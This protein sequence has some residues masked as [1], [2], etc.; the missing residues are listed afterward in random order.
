MEACSPF[1]LEMLDVF[2]PSIATAEGQSW[3]TQRRIATRCFNEQSNEIV[4]AE[5]LTLANDMLGYWYSKPE[6]TSAAN[7]LRTLSLHVLS[8]AGFGKSFKFQGHDERKKKRQKGDTVVDLSSNYKESLQ[9]VVENLVLILALGK[10]FIAQPWLPEGIQTVHKALTGFQS[11][12]TGMYE[13]EK[14]AFAAGEARDHNLMTGLIRASQDEAET[15]KEGESGGLTESEIY[16]NMFAFNFAGHD[17]VSHVCS[18][19]CSSWTPLLT[20]RHRLLPLH[21][22]SWQRTPKY[23]TGCQKKSRL[24]WPTGPWIN[25]PTAPTIL[26]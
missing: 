25:G 18:L 19:A 24:C 11:Y 22:T 17:T 16:G 21:S 10:R 4:W 15:G 8:R 13:E 6:L 1:V 20:L 2:G 9:I 5:A 23:R 7:D 3:K 14:R 26:V 12:M